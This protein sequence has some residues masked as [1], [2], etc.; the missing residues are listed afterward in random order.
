MGQAMETYW[1]EQCQLAFQAGITQ[2]RAAS[3]EQGQ[4]GS[5]EANGVHGQASS[6]EASSS[7]VLAASGVPPAQ[8]TQ[9]SNPVACP[10]ACPSGEAPAAATAGTA[11]PA[12][13]AVAS[14]PLGGVSADGGAPSGY[15]AQ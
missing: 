12:V 8:D 15:S 13:S 6:V 11:A 7:D 1:Q 14:V 3:G 10:P 9:P 5:A 4:A 2:G